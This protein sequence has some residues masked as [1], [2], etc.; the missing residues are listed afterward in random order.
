MAKV[1]MP[2]TD[3]LTG[4]WEASGL[5]AKLIFTFAMIAVF[6][7]GTQIPIFGINHEFFKNFANNQL[8]GF[9]D[10]FTGGAGLF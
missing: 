6:R 10:L 7:F 9:L 8:V 2:T 3:E 1:K 4:M 5:K